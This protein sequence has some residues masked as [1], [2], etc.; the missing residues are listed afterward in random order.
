[1]LQCD[2]FEVSKDK[3][4]VN[5]ILKMCIARKLS[6][7]DEAIVTPFRCQNQNLGFKGL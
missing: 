5:E 1:M 2:V 7:S 6:L 4:I 3:Y